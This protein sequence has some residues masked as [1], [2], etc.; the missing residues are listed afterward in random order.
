[1]RTPLGAVIHLTVD[2]P[3]Y[4][5]LQVTKVS[6]RPVFSIPKVKLISKT[7]LVWVPRKAN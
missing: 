6:H 5:D 3:I 1:M 4:S 2:G 7:V